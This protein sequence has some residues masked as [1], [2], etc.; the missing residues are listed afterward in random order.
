MWAAFAAACDIVKLSQ[1]TETTQLFAEF[2]P[3]DV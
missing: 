1:L 2:S 3:I